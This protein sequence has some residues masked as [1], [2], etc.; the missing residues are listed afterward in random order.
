[1]LLIYESY[2]K[3]LGQNI[4]FYRRRRD[5]TQEML[6]EM[7]DIHHV[8]MNRIEKGVSAPSLDIIFA[9]AEALEV[10]PYKLFQNKE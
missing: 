4:A 7:V 8:H 1:M 6:A 3:N 5:I 9:I 10:E 2:Y